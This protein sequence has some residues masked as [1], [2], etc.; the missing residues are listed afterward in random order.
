MGGGVWNFSFHFLVYSANQEREK[1]SKSL[2]KMNNDET[3]ALICCCG[4]TAIGEGVICIKLLACFSYCQLLLSSILR[5]FGQLQLR[6]L[7]I[8]KI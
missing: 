6:L 5:L 1:E 2:K 7:F 3:M 4:I 8:Y